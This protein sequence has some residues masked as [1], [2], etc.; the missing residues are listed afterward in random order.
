MQ[1]I[2][3]K[4][5]NYFQPECIYLTHACFIVNIS[6]PTKGDE[7]E[8]AL[9]KVTST[10]KLSSVAEKDDNGGPVT[11]KI[12]RQPTTRPSKWGRLLGSS[13]LDSSSECSQQAPAFTRSLSAKDASKDRPS[14]SSSG[15]SSNQP[16]P[17]NMKPP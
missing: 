8:K 5:N 1:V 10:T 15:N 6:Y 16:P 12:T 4:I 11:T 3:K 7:N 14:S 9:V 2:F 17:G 13:S